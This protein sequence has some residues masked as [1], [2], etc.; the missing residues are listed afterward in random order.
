MGF[1][2]SA[3][4]VADASKGAPEASQQVTPQDEIS[5]L[6]EQLRKKEEALTSKFHGLTSRERMLMQKEQEIKQRLGQVGD[7]DELK[8][9]A[10]KEPLKLL[11]RFGL[12][13]D[14]LTDIY[15]G[16]TPEDETKKT[17]STLKQEIESLKS[18]LQE[19]QAQ[20]QMKE[21]MRVKEAKLETLKSLASREGSGYDLV[22][23]FGNYDDVLAYMSEHYNATGEIL[24]DEEALEHI[25][26]RL[27]ESF[28]NISSNPRVKKLLGL[29]EPEPTR[30][31]PARPFGLSDSKFRTETPRQESTAN[32]SDAQIWELA[33]SKMPS[34]K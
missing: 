9:L 32:L 23:T 24:S 33:L 16:M 12:N 34:L 30:A 10:E 25:E 2:D 8:G 13:Y 26:S 20:G 1:I 15:A 11:E 14:K 17:V 3:G 21:I 19:D 5:Q 4:S 7:I 29:Q 18:K 31:E 22:S 27:A 28:K 6:K